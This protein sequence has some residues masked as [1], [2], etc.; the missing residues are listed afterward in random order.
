VKT[1]CAKLGACIQI[2]ELETGHPDGQRRLSGV[3]P[4]TDAQ[5]QRRR[6]YLPEP[7]RRIEEIPVAGSIHGY[8]DGLNSDIAMAFDE[9]IPYPSDY[10][11][12]LASTERTSRWAKR[13]LDH[14]HSDTQGLFGIVQGGMYE[15]LRKKSCLDLVDMDFDG[16]GIG[17]LSVGEEKD[18]MYDILEHTTPY[19]PQHKARYLMGVGTRRLPRR[20]RRPWRRY[21][22]LRISDA[23][24][25]QR[26]GHDPYGKA[27]RAQCPLCPRFPILLKKAVSAI[28]VAIIHGLTSAIS[29]KQK[30]CW[31]TVWSASIISIFY[32][33][34]CDKCV[35]L[36]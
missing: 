15:D 34:L 28:R 16:Y 29:S 19:L 9:C 33:T 30:N 22:R 4:G 20:R 24:S 17:G 14:H 13:C 10:D 23:G 12:T 1:W 11:Y 35:S 25:P 7:P 8:P 21:V 6:R 27:Y 31:H 5:N 36:Y 26:H 18:M 32:L 2:H 3:Q